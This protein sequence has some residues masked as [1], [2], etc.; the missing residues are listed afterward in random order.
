MGG[1][2]ANF[3]DE[4]KGRP[5]HTTIPENHLWI[6]GFISL[7]LSNLIGLYLT[8]NI[9]EFFWFFSI[10]WSFFTVTYDLELFHGFFHN[11]PS[12]ALSW[13]CVCLGS[14]YLQSLRITPQILIISLVYG[15]IAGYGRELYELAKP[16]SKDND[17]FASEESRYASSLLQRQILIINMIAIFL[18]TYRL[19][20]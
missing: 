10:V 6:V 19:V 20:L 15:S 16:F 14:Y 1:I 12:L 7:V 4:I 11:S 9:A 8:V 5:W 17:P 13:G 18:L 3:F 2:S